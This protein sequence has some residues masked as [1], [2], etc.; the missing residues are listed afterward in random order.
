MLSDYFA[1]LFLNLFVLL[2]DV[3]SPDPLD[4]IPF[5]SI[6]YACPVES[7]ERAIACARLTVAQT[8]T[9]ERKI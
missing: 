1:R 3:V 4:L 7:G 6:V 2:T 5:D 9:N 8:E